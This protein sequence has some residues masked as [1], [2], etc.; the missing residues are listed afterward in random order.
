LEA[1]VD[2]EIEVEEL[3]PRRIGVGR[4]VLGALATCVLALVLRQLL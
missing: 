4:F 2:Y 1:N 3:R